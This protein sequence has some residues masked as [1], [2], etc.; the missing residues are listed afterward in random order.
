MTKVEILKGKQQQIFEE[1]FAHLTSSEEMEAEQ[2]A[3]S[4]FRGKI[5]LEIGPYQ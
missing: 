2:Q 1:W 4:E 5:A 3:L